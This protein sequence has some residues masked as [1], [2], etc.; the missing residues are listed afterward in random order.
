MAYR[1]RLLIAGVLLAVLLPAAT[2]ATAQAEAEEGSNTNV[3]ITVRMGKLDGDQRVP[4]KSYNLVVA[5]GTPGSRLLAGERVP[6]PT[7]KGTLADKLDPDA[8]T[9][10]SFAYRNIGFVLIELESPDP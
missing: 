5:D 3:L 7:S 2:V 8:E 4:V 6:F 1:R 9:T 10:A